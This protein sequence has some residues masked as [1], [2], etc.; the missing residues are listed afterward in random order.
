MFTPIIKNIIPRP[1]LSVS[2][3]SA[4]T[5][6]PLFGSKSISISLPASGGRVLVITGSSFSYLCPPKENETDAA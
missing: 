4:A 5:A 3:S 6:A 2:A 1:V